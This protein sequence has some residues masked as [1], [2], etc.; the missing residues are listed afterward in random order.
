MLD[1]DKILSLACLASDQA[2][3]EIRSNA[4]LLQDARKSRG[5][6]T[7]VALQK[8]DMMATQQHDDV[9]CAAGEVAGA[10]SRMLVRLQ[11]VRAGTSPMACT[12]FQMS[13]F[14]LLLM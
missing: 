12:E 7:E 11:C 4:L 2:D 9:L 1:I 10:L 13:E 6:C 5:R 8:C 14:V 3:E